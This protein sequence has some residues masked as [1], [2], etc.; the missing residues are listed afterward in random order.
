[1]TA[2]PPSAPGIVVIQLCYSGKRSEG[3]T[4]VQAISSWEGGRPLFQ[5]FSE[6]TFE[7]Q[8]LAVEEVLKGGKGRKW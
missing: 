1:M 2:G 6:R 5:D 7:R 4:Y 3:E 8:Q